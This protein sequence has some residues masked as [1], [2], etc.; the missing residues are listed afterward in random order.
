LIE[1]EAVSEGPGAGAVW[2]PA[3]SADQVVA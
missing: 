1:V 2:P 3:V